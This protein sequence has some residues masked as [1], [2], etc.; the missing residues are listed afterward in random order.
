MNLP[1]IN[2]IYKTNWIKIYHIEYPKKYNPILIL[3]S[4][5]VRWALR[6]LSNTSSEIRSE[7][8]NNIY[9]MER[10]RRWWWWWKGCPTKFDLI[11]V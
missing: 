10:R 9:K 8:I 5:S 11:K 1:N 7:W 3:F 6:F 2:F 4:E